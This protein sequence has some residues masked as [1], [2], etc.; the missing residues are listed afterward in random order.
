MQTKDT[1]TPQGRKALSFWEQNAILMSIQKY[2]NEAA[3]PVRDEDRMAACLHG[4]T[5]TINEQLE[6]AASRK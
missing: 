6:H 5:D 2:V 3:K 4:I 1:K